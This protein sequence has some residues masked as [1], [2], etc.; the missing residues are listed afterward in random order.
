MK[1]IF[2]SFSLPSPDYKRFLHWAVA[3]Y[4]HV[5]FLNS[6]NHKNDPYSEFDAILATGIHKQICPHENQ[7]A[8]HD[9]K[10]FSQEHQ[11]W[12]FG[13]LS[14]ELKN[15]L[16]DLDSL[17][18]DGIQMP[19]MHFFIPEMVFIFRGNRV[20]IGVLNEVS[21]FDLA[22][23]SL[24]KILNFDIPANT[25]SP[26]NI[27]HRV[28]REEYIRKVGHIKNH[29]QKGDIYEM[30]YCIEF[31][32]ENTHTNP[33][34]CFL[35]LNK[36]NP[37]PY[38]CFYRYNE[39]YLLSSSPER[40]L[41][42]RGDILISQPIKGTIRRGRNPQEDEELKKQLFHDPKERSENVMIV[43]LVRNDLSQTAQKGSVMVNELFGI[44]TYPHVHQMI[45]TVV[46]KLQSDIHFT[47]AIKKAFPMGSM[48]GA[49][50]VRAMQIIEEYESTRRGLYSGA[51]GYISPNHNFDFNVIIR[52]ILY[53]QTNKFINFMAGSAIT[54][55]SEPEKEYQECLLKASS[56]AKAL[57]AKL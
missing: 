30:N 19:H 23:R 36:N 31:Y 47:D 26:I 44:Y 29:I 17:H 45:S 13:F 8:F 7:D 20:E 38:A 54:I 22:K 43:D 46:S 49:P 35:T 34:E 2:Q 37:S 55:R 42:K 16:E 56:M 9:L 11:D 18:P 28:T 57:N 32:A 14:Y 39:Q 52:S 53:N 10:T 15:Q 40:F 50:K 21:T 1:R 51:V 33:V 6:S 24:E 25:P 5:A 3:N 48:T 12:I 4:R 27:L 41:A